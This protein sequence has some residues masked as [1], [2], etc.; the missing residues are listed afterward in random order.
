MTSPRQRNSPPTQS[1]EQLTWKVLEDFFSLPAN[2]Q[3]LAKSRLIP[4]HIKRSLTWSSDEACKQ[5]KTPGVI[6]EQQKR[7][8]L[9]EWGAFKKSI[10]ALGNAAKSNVQTIRD[11]SRVRSIKSPASKTRIGEE[12]DIKLDMLIPPL[13]SKRLAML[14]KFWKNQDLYCEFLK[15]NEKCVRAGMDGTV[16]ITGVARFLRKKTGM[17]KPGVNTAPYFPTTD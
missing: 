3:M 7:T 14:R 8:Y 10:L 13:A 17:D 4:S 15:N 11:D 1:K 16:F 6:S 9:E 2:R 12:R 5:A